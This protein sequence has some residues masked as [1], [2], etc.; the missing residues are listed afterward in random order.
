MPASSSSVTHSDL[1]VKVEQRGLVADEGKRKRQVGWRFK[2][3]QERV[4]SFCRRLDSTMESCED[5][6]DISSSFKREENRS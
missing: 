3:E 5:G 4:G 2:D 6:S 1:N